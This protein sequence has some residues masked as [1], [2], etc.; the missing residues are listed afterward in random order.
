MSETFLVTGV[1]GFVGS[2]L[3]ERLLADGHQV[4]GI[5]CFTD[6][7]DVRIKQRNLEPLLSHDAFAFTGE[8]LCETDLDALLDGTGGVFHL[9]AQ[10][11]VR[12]SW[13]EQFET[14]IDANIRATQKLCEAARRHTIG[15][16]VYAGSSSVYGETAQ[17]PMNEAHPTRPVSPYGVTKLDAENL[18]L[19][20]GRNYGLPVVSLRFFTVFGPRQRPDMAFHRFIRAG[21]EG[22]PVTVFGNG[23]QT[24]D[25]TFVGDIVEANVAAMAYQGDELVFNIGGGN[26]VTVNRVLDIIGEHTS[27]RLDVRY[28]PVERGDVTHT[29]ADISRAAAELD[30]A[31]RVSLEEGIARETEWVRDIYRRLSEETSA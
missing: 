18:C 24:R 19:L 6:Y 3:A 27:G 4:R 17:L 31:P 12:A 9:A 22:D 15:K 5:D 7:Y 10:A 14:Y 21:L 25:F 20:Y 8:S 16:I 11:G 26:R 29:F 28:Q 23:E 2:H 1:A 13:G 30:Y